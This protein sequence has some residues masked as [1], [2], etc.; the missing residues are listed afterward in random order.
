M[1]LASKA[2]PFGMRQIQLTPL[3][4]DGAT[5]GT[6]VFLPVSRKLTFSETTSSEDLRGDDALQASHD[7]GAEVNWDLESGGISLDAYKVLNG[8]TTTQTGSTPNIK[9]TY[10]KTD[11][12]ARPYF[13]A[14]GRAISDSGGDFHVLLYRA[15]VTGDIGGELADGAFWL[16]SAS[17]KGY[18]SLEATPLGKIY[19]FVHNETAVALT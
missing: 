15:K 1:A 8:G 17:G 10:T 6:A 4:A 12:D 5:P 11:A 14:E 18:P 3:G 19:D 9:K 13:K 16:T 2:L 7:T